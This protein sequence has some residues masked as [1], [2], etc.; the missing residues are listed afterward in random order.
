M[1][2]YNSV[3]ESIIEQDPAWTTQIPKDLFHTV[4]STEVKMA[5]ESVRGRS[6][7][8]FDLYNEV[9]QQM[10]AIRTSDDQR[11]PRNC[12]LTTGRSNHIEAV[13]NSAINNHSIPVLVIANIGGVWHQIDFDAG[14]LLRNFDIVKAN[15]F[16]GNPITASIAYRPS[17]GRIINYLSLR[18]NFKS[19][20]DIDEKYNWYGVDCPSVPERFERLFE[21]GK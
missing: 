16:H 19:L 3:I 5:K 15:G 11:L 20:Q 1:S 7:P 21:N 4:F 6:T 8:I 2:I 12:I 13:I 18:F 14:D 10:I 9:T 17:G